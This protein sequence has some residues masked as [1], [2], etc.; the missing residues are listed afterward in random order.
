MLAGNATVPAILLGA[1]SSIVIV[2]F[3]VA[4]DVVD[5]NPDSPKTDALCPSPIA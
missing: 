2:T 5:I 1:L 4:A 3:L